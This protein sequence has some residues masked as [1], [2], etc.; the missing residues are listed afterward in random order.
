MV[1][2]WDPW[3]PVLDEL[4]SRVTAAEHGDLGALEG[5]APPAVQPAPM[6]DDDKRRAN[7]ILGRQRALLAQLRDERS[8]VVAAMSAARRVPRPAVPSAPVYVD[9]VG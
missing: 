5:W 2:G 7:G 4:D 3:G 9:R 1:D 6:A 8:E